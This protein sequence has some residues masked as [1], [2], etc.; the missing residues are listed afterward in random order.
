MDT[1]H[2]SLT[3]RT[4]TGFA[5]ELAAASPAPGG[6]S[7]AAL[8]GALSAGLIA[9][10]SRLTIGKEKFRKHE[11]E[12][13]RALD[14]ADQRRERLLILIDED[15]AAFN[16]VMEAFRLPKS[17]AEEKAARSRAIQGG[18]RGA[19]EVPLETAELCLEC[20]RDARLVIEHGNPNASS[21]ARTAGLMAVAGARAAEL[22]VRINL[23]SLKDE[24]V[25]TGLRERIEAVMSDVNRLEAELL[26]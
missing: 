16:R 17:T 9:M 7:V 3:N 15:T 11:E 18:L 6:G 12:L 5:A 26:R 19:A 13:Q 21:D 23:E 20:L 10:V 22:N 14:R 1:T 24:Q 4:V 25:Q 8:A 2:E